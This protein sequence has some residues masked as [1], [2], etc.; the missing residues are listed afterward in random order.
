MKKY[1]FF[2][3]SCVQIE[4]ETKEDAI[5]IYERGQFFGEDIELD[6]DYE[7]REA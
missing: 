5:L 4:A 7:V 1:N 6:E 3:R 2:S